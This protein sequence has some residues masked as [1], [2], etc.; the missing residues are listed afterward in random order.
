MMDRI[1]G[2]IFDM[3]GVLYRANQRLAGAKEFIELLQAQGVPFA[4]LTNNSTRTRAQYAQKL[5]AMEILVPKESIVTS[6]Q[7]TAEYL[8][9]IAP[10]GARVYVIGEDGIRNALT[11]R[12]FNLVD[13]T[14]AHYV[15]VG[16]DTKLTYEK[17]RRAALAIR[18]G[19]T[20][21]GT[22][23]DRT[24]PAPDGLYPGTG[25]LLALLE[26]ATDVQPQVIGK[27]QPA[28]F[29][30]AIQQTGLS[31]TGTAVVGDQVETDIRGGQA[32]GLATILVMTGASSRSDLERS[33]LQPDWVFNDLGALM[34]AWQNETEVRKS[35]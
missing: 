9:R 18:A 22:N 12:G 31:K 24:F 13:D 3:D 30:L 6:A 16:M 4:L 7:A 35:I 29:E 14:D 33:G 21:M 25:S 23:P 2:F 10:Q 20:F 5:A 8:A 27:P 11:Q 19:A 17:L 28:I 34:K 15:V 32:A 26:S 1:T